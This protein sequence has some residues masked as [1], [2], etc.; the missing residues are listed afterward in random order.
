[1]LKVLVP[2]ADGSEEM[3]AVIIVDILRR[4][5][6]TV[7]IASVMTNR[8]VIA[9]RGVEIEADCH[10]EY[11]QNKDWDMVVIPGGMPGAQHMAESL[12]L[13]DIIADQ[14]SSQRWL[15][16]ICAAPAVVLAA[17]GFIS[18]ASATCYPAFRDVL[19]QHNVRAMNEPVSIYKKLVTG[20]GPGAAMDFALTLVALLVGDVKADGIARDMCFS[21]LASTY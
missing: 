10:I 16:A 15:A 21:R 5:D 8:K 6:I 7:S 18:G 17:N 4:A 11:C 13:R 19:E 12:P 9:S 14:I 20:Q 1:M 3:E 2:I